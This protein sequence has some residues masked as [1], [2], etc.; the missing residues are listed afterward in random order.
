MGEAKRRKVNDPSFGR[1]PKLG[2]GLV[3]SN[4]VT[5]KGDNYLSMN[6]ELDAIELK[7]AVLFWDKLVWPRNNIVNWADSAEVEFL[8]SE[9]IMSRPQGKSDAIGKLGASEIGRLHINEY[10]RLDAM[11]PGVWAISGGPSSFNWDRKD[12]VDARGTLVTLYRAIPIPEHDVPLE[13]LLNFKEARRDEVM[14]L[15]LE[16]DALYSRI[17]AAIDSDFE[18]RSCIAKIDRKAS[19]M[20]RVC[21]ESKIP[22]RLSDLGVSFSNPLSRVPQATGFALGGLTLMEPFGLHAVGAIVGGIIPFIKIDNNRR[23]RQSKKD[24]SPYRF[25]GSLHADVI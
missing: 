25:V 7:R 2:R 15:A 17:K 16:I 3:I 4:P 13:D 11:E 1:Y 19:D 8:I 6:T 24:T 20:I 22:F 5:I 14:D 18:M 23:L 21:R 12:D 10:I 9:G